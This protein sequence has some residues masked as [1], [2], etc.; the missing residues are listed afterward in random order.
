MTK[1]RV[2][3]FYDPDVPHFHY[4]SGHPMKPQRLALTNSLVFSY[5]LYK[6]MEVTFLIKTFYILQWLKF[7]IKHYLLVI[8]LDLS[9]LQSYRT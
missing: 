3:Y 6:K 4:G 1:R 5:D 8:I 9:I 2:S 7:Y